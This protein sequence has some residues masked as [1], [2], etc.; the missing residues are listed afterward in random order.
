[1]TLALVAAF[2]I[3]PFYTTVLGGF[4][5][6]GELRTNPFGLPASWDPANFT[7]IIFETALFRSL[8]NSLIIALSTVVL[9]VLVASMAAF[10]LAHIRFFGSKFL[11]SFFMLGLLFPASPSCRSSS[12]CAIS[13]C[14]TATWALSLPRW[15]SA[16]PFRSCCFTASSNAFPR[17]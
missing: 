9:S 1:M 12:N 4:K 13:G 15:H 2:I 16:S 7:G 6:V 17:S 8:W 11:M 14:S 10:A 3:V 5:S